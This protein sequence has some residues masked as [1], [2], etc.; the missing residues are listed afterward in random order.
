VLFAAL[1]ALLTGELALLSPMFHHARLPQELRDPL[2]EWLAV[3]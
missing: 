3:E 1:A 2:H